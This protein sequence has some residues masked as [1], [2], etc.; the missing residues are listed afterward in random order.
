MA[1]W[2]TC[3]D[4]PGAWGFEVSR[5]IGAVCWVCWSAKIWLARTE[6]ERFG[7]ILGHRAGIEPDEVI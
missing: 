3:R 7:F 1:A 6:R 4:L 2:A 5:L